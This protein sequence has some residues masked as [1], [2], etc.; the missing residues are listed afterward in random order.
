MTSPVFPMINLKGTEIERKVG[1]S[2]DVLVRIKGFKDKA[3]GR[4]IHG[5][6]IWSVNGWSGEPDVLEWW[7]L[8]D[9]ETGNTVG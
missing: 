1:V 7:P 5:S 4:Y 9:N 6:G 3:I 2:V 8:P